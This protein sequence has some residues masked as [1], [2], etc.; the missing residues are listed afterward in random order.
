MMHDNSLCMMVHT[1][2][3][4]SSIVLQYGCLSLLHPDQFFAVIP[5]CHDWFVYCDSEGFPPEYVEAVTVLVGSCIG[6]VS[7]LI[8]SHP[9]LDRNASMP[10]GTA[11]RFEERLSGLK[12]AGSGEGTSMFMYKLVHAGV[13]VRVSLMLLLGHVVVCVMWLSDSHFS[14]MCLT[15]RPKRPPPSRASCAATWGVIVGVLPGCGWACPGRRC[16]VVQVQHGADRAAEAENTVR[17]SPASPASAAS[18]AT[19]AVR[20]GQRQHR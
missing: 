8:C 6:R 3:H 11:L 14:A 15:R 1:H 9:N 16:V 2:S 19:A 7:G 17:D 5:D 12:R 10:P 13:C 20:R 18:T 4:T